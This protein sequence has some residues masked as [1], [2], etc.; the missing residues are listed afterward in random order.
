M[1]KAGL[2][3][4]G[5]EKLEEELL[6]GRSREQADR[7]ARWACADAGR[8]EDLMELFLRGD[9]RVAQRAAWIVGICAE[10]DLSLIVPYL[11][12]M[13]RRMQEPA[14]HDAVRR[15]VVRILQCVEVPPALMGRVATVC[16]DYLADPGVPAAIRVFSMSVLDRLAQRVP[17]LRGE[18]NLVIDQQLPFA[19]AAFRARARR[20]LRHS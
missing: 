11:A 14:V 9:R 15:C 6:A 17:S 13:V 3:I 19:G 5:V 8:M 1:K 10:R 12:R 16:F 7:L 4:S 18:L 20:V 2:A